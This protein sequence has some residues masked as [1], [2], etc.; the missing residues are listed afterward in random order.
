MTEAITLTV[1][2]N[3]LEGRDVAV[4]D[5]PGAYLSADI[6]DEVHVVFRG[7]LSELMVEVDP[8]LYQRFMSYTTVQAVL[9]IRPKKSMYVCLKSE[10]LFC[11]KLL[12]DLEAHRFKINP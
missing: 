4:V 10:L 5:I 11:E 6:D 9:Y 12:R 2:I 1:R 3:T 7:A 8:E